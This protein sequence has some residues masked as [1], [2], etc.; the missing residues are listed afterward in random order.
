MEIFLRNIPPDLSEDALERELESFM[1]TLSI[2]GWTCEKPRRKFHAWVIFLNTADGQKFMQKHGQISNVATKTT[3]TIAIRGKPA[4]QSK[5]NEQLRNAPP[6]GPFQPRN[7]SVKAQPR[8]RDMARL[9]ITNTPIF[10]VPSTR[11]LNKHMLSHLKER[12]HERVEAPKRD[13]VAPALSF[14]I[15]AI[16]CGSNMFGT[17]KRLTFSRQSIFHSFSTGKL[18]QRSLSIVTTSRFRIDIPCDTIQDFV[19]GHDDDSFTL[20]LTEPPRFYAILK[21]QVENT[22]QWERRSHCPDWPSHEKYAGRCLV[23]QLT[24]ADLDFGGKVREI[25]NRDLISV[26]QETL[27]VDSSPA[28]FVN[29]YTTSMVAFEGKVHNPRSWD[30]QLPFTLLFQVQALVFNNYLH[31]SSAS[32]ML[33]AMNKVALDSKK[34]KVRLPFTVDSMKKL[35]QHI[36]YPC[37]GTDPSELDVNELVERVMRMERDLARD[38]PLRHPEYG[39]SIPEHQAWV[40]KAMV[41]PTRVIFHGPEAES[42]NRILR[43]YPNHTNQFVRVLFC[44]DDG[45]DLSFNPK[46]SNEEVYKRYRKILRDGL[47]VAGKRFSFL[48]F[49]H[50]SLRSHS[51]WFVSSF[52]DDNFIVQSYDT[53]VSALGKFEDIRVPAK[54]AARIGQA[55]SETPYAVPLFDLGI[56]SRYIPDVKNADGSRVFSDGVGTISRE[57][58]EMFWAHLPARA[59]AATCFQ[60]RWGGAKGMLALDSRLKGKVFCVRNESMMKYSSNDIMEVGICDTA[61]RPLRL[62]LNRQMIKI[63]EDM[64]T[65]DTWFLKMQTRELNFLRA[66]TAQAGNTSTFLRY[67][68]IGINMGLPQFIRQIDRMGIDYRRDV[69]LKTIVE[70]VV[71]RELRLL[72]YK[73]RI[74]VEKGVTLFGIMDETG[75]LD[76]DEIYITF[77]EGSTPVGRPPPHGLALVTRSPALHPGDIRIATMVTPPAGSPLRDLRN[78]IVFSQNGDRDL[79]SQLSGGDLDG[80]LYNVIWDPEAFPERQFHP[81]D[82]PRVNPEPLNREVTRDDIADFF[83]NF[84]KTDVLG[85]IATRHLI[86]ADVDDQGTR[87]D[88]CIKLA[89]LHSTAVDSSKTGIPVNIKSLPKAPRTRPDL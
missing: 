2:V 49:S 6:Q 71:M 9:F 34:Q 29:D 44:D 26:T 35:F 48:G 43:K 63:L 55:F 45:Q 16:S 57:A 4:P 8:P 73:A 31:P 51:V 68:L 60:I 84:M 7:S 37:P 19:A 85:M 1:K 27:P 79:P 25:K 50:S 13:P 14:A 86:L 69:F 21:N 15:A 65:I 78:C 52:T 12:Q 54:C 87:S 3:T 75:Y 47:Q 20:V 76:K 17:K 42:K 67:Q 33:D 24:I 89:E 74:P 30:C 59:A 83:I 53:I 56:Q 62:M 23:Y 82:Y 64:G 36:P 81:A 66:V 32:K 46:V 11:K 28:P 77:D 40:M 58:M 22:T 39:A 80:D 41:T 10:A 72:K 70:H 18:T 38:D 61:S 88:D 5:P